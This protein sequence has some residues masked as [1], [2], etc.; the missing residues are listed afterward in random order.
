MRA[1]S[2]ISL[3]RW[4]PFT[5]APWLAPTTRMR[6]PS[7]VQRSCVPWVRN[8]GPLGLS[9]ILAPLQRGDL[10][11]SGSRLC[12]LCRASSA[13]A[14]EH[15]SCEG[16]REDLAPC[17]Q[18]GNSRG[19]VTSEAGSTCA[20]RGAR[21]GAVRVCGGASTTRVVNPQ[22][23]QHSMPVRR[24]AP[25]AQQTTSQLSAQAHRSGGLGT[26]QCAELHAACV[27]LGAH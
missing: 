24:T 2:S 21:A 17:T 25:S 3:D 11:S 18:G 5:G 14:R 22:T 19:R 1:L 4:I 13:F 9:V 6:R 8:K 20:T 10:G 23:A 26:G 16:G 7:C 12:G 27:M 15:V